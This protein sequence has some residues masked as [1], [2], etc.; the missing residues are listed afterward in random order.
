MVGV[1]SHASVA[2]A[3]PNDGTA[4]HSI[5]E[6]TDGQVIIGGVLSSTT[7]VLLQ[8]EVLPQSSVAVQVLVTLYSCGHIPLGVVTV[9]K[10]ILTEASQPSVAVAVPKEGTAGQLIGETTF[11]HVITGGVLSTTTIVLLQEAVLPQSSVA[12][13]VLVTLYAC[14]QTPPGVV[15]VEKVIDTEGSQ[16]SVAVATPKEGTAGQLMGDTTFGQVMTGGVLSWTTIVLLHE[17]VFPQSSVATHV[18]VTL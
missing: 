8:V 2:D 5:G 15:T 11:G 9:E 12:T 16:A 18:L 14:E 4:G 10:V 7:I 6:I 13:Q 17:D 3:L 1:T